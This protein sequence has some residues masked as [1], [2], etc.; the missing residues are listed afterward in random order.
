MKRVFFVVVVFFAMATAHAQEKGLHLIL[1]GGFGQTNFIYDLKG[2]E[3][4]HK[5]GYGGYLGAQY[6]FNRHWGISLSGEFFQFNTQIIFNFTNRKYLLDGRICG[7]G[8]TH[9]CG[10]RIGMNKAKN[11]I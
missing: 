1:G 5:V 8:A 2:G 4:R 3:Y 6:F 11:M 9:Q 7:T 10:V